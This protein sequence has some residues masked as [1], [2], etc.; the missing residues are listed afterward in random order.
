MPIT[1]GDGETLSVNG[2]RVYEAG[3]GARMGLATLAAS[4]VVVN[5]TAVTANSRIFLTSQSNTVTGALRVSART[6]G[7][8]FTIVDA[9]GAEA[10][11]VAW[12]LV[13]P[14]V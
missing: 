12:M 8:S 6:P 9:V 2:V 13:E 7:T 5:T 14:A 10:G 4:T 1:V 3:T 11:T